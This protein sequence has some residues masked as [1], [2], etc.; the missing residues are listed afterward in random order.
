M[1]MILAGEGRERG[2]GARGRVGVSGHRETVY[3]EREYL[4]LSSCADAWR[5]SAAVDREPMLGTA[6]PCYWDVTVWTSHLQ[7]PGQPN[8][9]PYECNLTSCSKTF[10]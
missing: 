4:K 7:V 2:K 3:G 8:T 1:E 9:P 10:R 5:G 6:A